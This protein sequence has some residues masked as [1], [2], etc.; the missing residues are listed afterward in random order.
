MRINV[1]IFEDKLIITKKFFRRFNQME[2]HYSI[3]IRKLDLLHA[4]QIP[5]GN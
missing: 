5:K 2:Y 3:I 1:N 4:L